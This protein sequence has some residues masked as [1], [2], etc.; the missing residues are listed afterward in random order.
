MFQYIMLRQ[1]S[2]KE[3]Y[4]RNFLLFLHESDIVNS[5]SNSNMKGDLQS[6]LF[7]QILKNKNNPNFYMFVCVVEK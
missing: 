5:E 7:K 3:H 2:P 6:L 1:E 4:E